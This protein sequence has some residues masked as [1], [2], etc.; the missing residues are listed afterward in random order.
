MLS[1]ATHT[2][3]PTLTHTHPTY[4]HTHTLTHTPL[5]THACTRSHTHHAHTPHTITYIH[6]NIL[7][8]VL[9]HVPHTPHRFTHTL[10]HIST[11]S[12]QTHTFC[13][14][15]THMCLCVWCTLMTTL[16]HTHTPQMA[17]MSP[18]ILTLVCQLLGGF[19]KS[20]CSPK[21]PDASVST[22]R[23]VGHCP[24]LSSVVASS[25]RSCQ[26]LNPVSEGGCPH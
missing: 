17:L 22:P 1:H 6:T 14:S 19:L 7:S 4:S 20:L 21:L 18:R 5:Y 13:T 15:R 11:H 9:S 16:T 10:T 25:P 8:H 26:G 3:P 24:L 23:S 2:P 12:T